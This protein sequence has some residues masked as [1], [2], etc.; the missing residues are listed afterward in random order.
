M[1]PFGVLTATAAPF[2]RDNID[3]D[4]IIRIERLVG[5]MGHADLGHWCFELLRYLPDGSE[6]PDFILNQEPYRQ[7]EVLL[8]GANFGCGSS[9]EGA[10]WAM[11]G[12][13]LKAVLAPSFG[14]IFYNNCFQNGLLPIVLPR[15]SIEEII[16]ELRPDSGGTSVTV[17]LERQ[18]VV[19]P[20]G[21][22]YTFETPPLRRQAL[23]DGVEADDLSLTLKREAEIAAF[24]ARDRW[25]RPW[26]YESVEVL[27]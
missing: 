14:Q 6:N 13:G 17:D 8:A 12:M 5:L 24:Q 11:M 4:I 26:I 3:T 2:L 15:T 27:S 20:G 22:E 9:R 19:S 25:R 18:F 21:R 1:K 7:S 16:S 10:V 23:L